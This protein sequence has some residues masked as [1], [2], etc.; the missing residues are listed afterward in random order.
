MPLP[1]ALVLRTAG[2]N[3]DAETERALRLSGADAST[4]HLNRLLEEPQR[5]EEQ[6]ILVIA[7]GF[8]YGDDVAAGRVWGLELRHS[9]AEAL[10]GFVDRGGL[11]LGV[12]NGFQVLVE[13]G[14]FDSTG[15]DGERDIA[16]TNNESN[17][18]ECRWVTLRSEACACPWIVPGELMPTPVAHAE[19]RFVVKSN[20]TLERLRQNNQI[21]LTYVAPDG[22][23]AAYP[24]NPNGAVADI[25]GICDPTGRVLGLMPHPERNL[26]PWNHPQWTRLSRERS[27]GEGLPFYER[28][29]ACAATGLSV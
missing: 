25:A 28:M 3:C 1:K 16:L 10:K 9:L 11:A 27:H 15:T 18:Y 24:Q 5:L 29:V 13:S 2:T 22:G 4:L 19:G 8:S 26:D 17:H 23:P 12:C 14:L 21:A 20:E 7:G 6:E